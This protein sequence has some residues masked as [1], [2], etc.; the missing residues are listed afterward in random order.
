MHIAMDIA[1]ELEISENNENG[2]SNHL[3]GN[4]YSKN[5]VDP[6]T[7]NIEFLDQFSARSDESRHDSHRRNQFP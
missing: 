7:Q 6:P 3:A 4:S 5:Y 1:K 2:P